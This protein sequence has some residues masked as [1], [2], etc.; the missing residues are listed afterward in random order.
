M[1]KLD[2]K[3]QFKEL[4]LPSTKEVSVVTVPAM[5]FLMVDGNGDPNKPPLFQ[6]AC[7]ALYGVA[8]TLKF[9]LKPLGKTPEFTIPPL[10]GL[11]W[12]ED[13]TKPFSDNKDEWLWTLMIAQPDFVT[14]EQVQQAVVEVRKKKNP[15]ALPKLRFERFEE[16]LAAQIMHIGSYS[17]ERENIEMIHSFIKSSGK[18]IHGKHHEIYLS[19]PRRVPEEKLKTVVRQGMR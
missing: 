15:V 13:T 1:E 18:Y 5:N 8:Y 17:T 16:G 14:T 4:Y 2:L 19:D 11:W 12:M 9:I 3:K 6:E 10:E 7:E